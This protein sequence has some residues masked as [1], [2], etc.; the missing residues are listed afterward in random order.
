MS[1]LC[2]RC[3][4]GKAAVLP[5]GTVAVCEIG[6]FLTAG[7]V[8]GASLASVLAGE[9]WAEVAASVARRAGAAP[10]D[11]DCSPNDD[12]CQPSSGGTCGPS[13]G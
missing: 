5:D 1:S 7:S 13:D 9:R 4:D 10:C 8:R 11:P 6:R 3:G 12:T 2:G